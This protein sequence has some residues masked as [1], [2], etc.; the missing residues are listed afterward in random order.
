MSFG[1]TNAPVTYQDI[2]EAF[3]REKLPPEVQNA[4]FAHIDDPILISDG[5]EEHLR[6]LEIMLKAMAEAKLQINPDK[7]EFCYTQVNYL[8]FIIDDKDLHADPEKI[9]AIKD[10]KRPSNLK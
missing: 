7:S 4:T 2:M 5:F 1:L 10:Y 8:G 3:L 6:F 9:Q